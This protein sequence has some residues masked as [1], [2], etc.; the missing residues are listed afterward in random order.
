MNNYKF[1]IKGTVQKVYYRK[2]VCNNAKKYNF[3]GY[4]KNLTNG[5]VEACITCKDD[6]LDIF[7]Q[8]LQKGSIK[9]KVTKIIRS[10]TNTTFT[11]DFRVE[12]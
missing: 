9:S 7:L 10:K 4:V 6:E 5:D 11:K 1:I 12:Y 3:K 8:I 2:T